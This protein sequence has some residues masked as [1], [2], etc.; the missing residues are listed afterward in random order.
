[1]RFPVQ[2]WNGKSERLPGLYACGLSFFIIFL[3]SFAL[4]PP[5]RYEDERMP[6]AVSCGEVSRF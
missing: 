6:E 4:I 1:M 2:L 3:F 5:F